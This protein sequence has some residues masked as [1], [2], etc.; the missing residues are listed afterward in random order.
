MIEEQG[1]RPKLSDN[2]EEAA[3]KYENEHTF[4]KYEGGYYSDITMSEAFKAGAQWQKDQMN[5]AWLKDREGC[6]WDG[7]NE[8]K[9]AMKDQILKEAVEGKIYGDIKDQ[10]DE[11]YEI[12]AESYSLPKDKFHLHENV[13]L[14]IIK[15]D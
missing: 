1:N 5:E 10:E 11:P 2:L 4:R 13:K 12:W 15:G 3:E 8:G 7:V 6:F 9:K 14:V